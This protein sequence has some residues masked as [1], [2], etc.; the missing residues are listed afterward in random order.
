MSERPGIAVVHPYWTLWEHTAGPSF[1]SDRL[2][3]S[4]T[5]T[6]EMADMYDLLAVDDVASVEEGATLGSRLAQQPPD[7]LL[8]I[9]SMAAPPAYILATIEAL[10]QTPVVVWAMHETG[11]VGGDFDHGGITTQG[12]TVGAPMLTNMLAR[13]KRPFELILGRAHDRTTT[14]RPNRNPLNLGS[15]PKSNFS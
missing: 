13:T 1:R 15:L 3:L 12:A 4:R 5:V 2:A 10:P 6:S 7:A 11:L 9:V 8:V 14:D